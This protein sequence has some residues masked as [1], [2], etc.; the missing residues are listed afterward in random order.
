MPTNNSL[1][2]TN[3]GVSFSIKQCR[4]F[5]ID[6]RATL[7]WLIED[8]GFRRFRL[9]TYW[10]EHEK[11]PDNT[12][13]SELDWQI[14]QIKRA[15][16]EISLCLGARQPRWPENHWPDWAWQLNK[17]ERTAALLKYIETVVNRYRTEESIASYQ[18]E[19]EALLESFGTRPEVDRR[20]LNQEYELIKALDPTRPI[21]MTTSTSW[22]IPIRQPRPDIVGFSFYQ[23]L[24]RDGRYSTAF[25]S[26][27]LDRMRAGLVGLFYG[28]PCFIHELQLEPWGPTAIWKMPISEQDI[29]MGTKQ[30]ERNLALAHITGLKPVDLWGGEWWYYRLKK[31]NDPTIWQAVQQGIAKHAGN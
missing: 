16:G 8:A 25:H 12:D 14:D 7:K 3:F 9:M 11:T 23:K 17:P 19:N 15:N 28:A 10:N 18:L 31:Q 1:I 27:W 22:G 13:F 6:E 4:N 5:G 24:Y 29:S 21:I 30:I 2:A 20:R 26:P